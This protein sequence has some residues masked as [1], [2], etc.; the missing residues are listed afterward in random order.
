M[1]KKYIYYYC[2]AFL[3]SGTCFGQ[4]VGINTGEPYGIF[5]VSIEENNTN[6]TLNNDDLIFRKNENS[7]ANLIIGGQTFE[8]SNYISLE[9]K[10][11]HKAMLLNRVEITPGI[12]N[13]QRPGMIVFNTGGSFIPG[14]YLNMGNSWQQWVRLVDMPGQSTNSKIATFE[15]ATG[16]SGNSDNPLA[17]NTN[18]NNK[19]DDGQGLYSNLYTIPDRTAAVSNAGRIKY[20]DID[21]DGRYIFSLRIY[22]PMS[23]GVQY[24]HCYFY[25][26]R[27]PNDDNSLVQLTQKEIV[28][29]K[30][31]GAWGTYNIVMVSPL[32]NAGD[33]IWLK[34]GKASDSSSNLG[35][36]TQPTTYDYPRCNRSSLIF[37]KL[38]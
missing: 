19:I 12:I 6:T 16:V 3:S 8:P 13:S 29:V 20:I 18:N 24:G 17:V 14:I 38:K 32:L 10:D 11:D 2:F 31:A 15:F 22:G 26:F 36:V 35:L 27:G 25:L 23:S 33:R 37:W 4:G 21:S 30:G 9:L 34:I 1:K 28:L 7:E 5:D